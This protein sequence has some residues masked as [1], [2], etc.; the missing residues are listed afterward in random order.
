MSKRVLV[1][2]SR[3]GGGT[4]ITDTTPTIVWDHEVPCLEEIHGEGC[5]TVIDDHNELLDKDIVSNRSKQIQHIVTTMRLGEDFNGDPF[6]EY[7]RLSA[8]YGMHTEV[9]MLIVEK[10]YGAF[11]KGEFA[12]VVGVVALEE[13]SVGQLREMCEDLGLEFKPADKKQVL[14]DAIRDRRAADAE[15]ADISAQH[16]RVANG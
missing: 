3:S 12:K 9:R 13:L 15:E 1:L 2:V 14:A 7:Q 8:K 11:R 10:V 5:C 16:R 4:H 6:D